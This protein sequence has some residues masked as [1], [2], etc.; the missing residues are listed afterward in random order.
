MLT[1]HLVGTIVTTWFMSRGEQMLWRVVA[2]LFT[3]PHRVTIPIT[4]PT[5]R[6]ITIHLSHPGSREVG[7]GTSVRGPPR[8]CALAL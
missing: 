5:W 3:V 2:R 8:R 1:A 4:T 6:P 7:L